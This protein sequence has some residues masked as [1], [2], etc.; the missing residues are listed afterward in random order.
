MGQ[1]RIKKMCLRF[2]N[3]GDINRPNKGNLCEEVG[4][5]A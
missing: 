5:E 4:V 2:Y 1:V 3:L